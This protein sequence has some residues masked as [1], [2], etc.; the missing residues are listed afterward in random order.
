M[1]EV[2]TTWSSILGAITSGGQPNQAEVMDIR[3]VKGKRSI[4]GY[5]AG[6]MSRQVAGDYSWS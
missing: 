4:A 2:G 6:Y 5:V 3:A 1:A